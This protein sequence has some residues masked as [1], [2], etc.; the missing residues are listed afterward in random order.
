[1]WR[2]ALRIK[3]KKGNY[4]RVNLDLAVSVLNVEDT[5]VIFRFIDGS[6]FAFYDKDYA[7]EEMRVLRV[8]LT[9]ID[10]F[11]TMGEMEKED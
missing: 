3:T 7:K 1:M 4:I 8:F 2:R 5:S 9:E 11:A 10:H 6:K